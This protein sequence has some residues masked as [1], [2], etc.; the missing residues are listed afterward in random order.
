VDAAQV[1]V[2]GHLCVRQGLVEVLRPGLRDRPVAEAIKVFVLDGN[3]PAPMGL[4]GLLFENVFHDP[5]PSAG[6]EFGVN[7]VQIDAGQR[8][9]EMR[10][11]LGL[12][13]GLE[14]PLGFLPVARFEAGLLAGGFVLEVVNAPRT[15]DQSELL[16]HRFAHGCECEAVGAVAV[17]E[18]WTSVG[19]AVDEFCRGGQTS[20]D[21][22]EDSTPRHF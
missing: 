1:N 14:K 5:L 2:G 19:R 6:A 8:E 3:F 9:V 7:P 21:S 18:Q 15:L 10:L 16:L 12:I 22:G 17:S 13:V 4:A 20:E 11:A